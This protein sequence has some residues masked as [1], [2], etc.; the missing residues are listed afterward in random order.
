VRAV[1]GYTVIFVSDVVASLEFYERAFELPRRYLASEGRYANQYAELETG[2]TVLALVSNTLSATYVPGG[3]RLNSRADRPAG[4]EVAFVTDD[5]P[6]LYEH[7]LRCGAAPV[8]APETKPWGQTI[9]YVLDPNGVLVEI[10][11][12]FQR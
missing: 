2:T 7:A 12:R 1:F 8:S 9:S 4:F 6:A 5:V 10:C 11:T 3:F